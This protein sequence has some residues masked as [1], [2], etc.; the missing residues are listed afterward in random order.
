MQFD[1]DIAAQALRE[2]HN[3]VNSAAELIIRRSGQLPTHGGR[4]TVG[5]IVASLLSE[6]PN[7]ADANL[8]REVL[9]AQGRDEEMARA[10]LKSMS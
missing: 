10:Y 6:F 4:K 7:F 2:T 9:E 1:G 8:V 3:D 5:D